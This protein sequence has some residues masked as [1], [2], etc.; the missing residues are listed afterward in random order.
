MP[1]N[2]T[3]HMVGCVF[4]LDVATQYLRYIRLARLRLRPTRHGPSLSDAERTPAAAPRPGTKPP[5]LIAPGD[6]RMWPVGS[7]STGARTTK[8][9]R[10][11]GEV[12]AEHAT[13]ELEPS[14][15]RPGASPGAVPGLRRIP[16]P[17]P[18]QPRHRVLNG[19]AFNA[20]VL[21]MS[22]DALRA[23]DFAS[24][25]QRNFRAFGYDDQ[26]LL[27]LYAGG[28]YVK[29]PAAW[30]MDYRNF[31][32]GAAGEQAKIV[33][34]NGADKPWQ[35]NVHNDAGPG[36]CGSG[37]RHRSTTARRCSAA[38]NAVPHSR[39]SKR[40]GCRLGR[41]WISGQSVRP[42]MSAQR[43]SLGRIPLLR[44]IHG[45]PCSGVVT[46]ERLPADVAPAT[47]S[48]PARRR[49]SGWR[50]AGR[51]GSGTGLPAAASRPSS[52]APV[53]RGRAGAPPRRPPVRGASAT[54]SIRSRTRPAASA[55]P[56]RATPP[57][58]A[59]PAA[60]RP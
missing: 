31:F 53:R 34:W 47:P 49:G 17:C 32:F 25:V 39:K 5:S 46:P 36:D 50:R 30:N 37:I 13:L 54:R 20:G 14:H 44:R 45:R 2:T 4:T 8:V 48:S 21:L 58:R 12:L 18:D 38:W 22:L 60:G 35:D 9:A 57:R 7:P 16:R 6:G 15:R 40:E 56:G 42:D 51:A 27:N 3:S 59:S 23:D 55:A 28:D 24:Q 52:T 41:A 29:L 33:H 11:A 10:N 26:T 1:E 19:R 43:W